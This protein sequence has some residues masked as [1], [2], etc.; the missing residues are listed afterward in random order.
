[1]KRFGKSKS[2]IVEDKEM[3]SK[4]VWIER[5]EKK[6]SSRV[7]FGRIANLIGFF[8]LLVALVLQF[9]VGA[10]RKNSFSEDV[11]NG[12]LLFI[13]ATIIFL[14]ISP[15][16]G[17]RW[18]EVFTHATSQRV[19]NF[20]LVAFLGS[21][22]LITLPLAKRFGSAG[23]I[24]RHPGGAAWVD[25]RDYRGLSTWSDKRFIPEQVNSRARGSLVR[26][27]Q[28][29]VNQRNWLALLI[30]LA[31]IVAASLFAFASSPVIAPFIYPI[32]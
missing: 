29:F 25:G 5:R 13:L 31:L 8:V 16:R 24:S 11:V 17:M 30:V 23:F 21:L 18:I 6:I 26:T 15:D 9:S 2:K 28:F 19:T 1:M 12:L 20:L 27:L 14:F 10:F 22:Y 32:F 3:V 7:A 4:A